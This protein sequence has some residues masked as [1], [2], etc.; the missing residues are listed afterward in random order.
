MCIRDSDTEV[1]ARIKEEIAAM[2][3]TDYEPVSFADPRNKNVASIQFI[4]MTDA[5]NGD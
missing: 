1:E 4:F 2:L 5:I 3:G